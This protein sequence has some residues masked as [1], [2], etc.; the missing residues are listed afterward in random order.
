MPTRRLSVASPTVLALVALAGCGSRPQQPTGPTQGQAGQPAQRVV[1]QI[2]GTVSDTAFRTV[3]GAKVEILN[4][5]SAGTVAVSEPNGSVSFTGTFAG[6]VTFRATRDG[7]LP[8]T[9]V[10]DVAGLCPQCDAR[11]AFGMESLDP[12][13]SIEPGDYTLT[14]VAD[15]ACTRLPVELRTRTYA[16]TVTRSAD[17]PGTFDVRVPGM[18]YEHGWFGLGISGNI[19][20]TIDDSYPTFFDPLPQSAYLGIDF[21]IEAA[22]ESSTPSAI[23]VRFPGTFEYCALKTG[24]IDIRFCEFVQAS[25]LIAHDR[26]YA[27]QHQMILSRR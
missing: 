2:R 23:S 9:Q 14:F 3:A 21:A 26:C 11:I 19:V 7:Y 1:T 8:A 27:E 12:T 17:R 22:L 10:L 13:A 4:G 5:P 6:V 25:N 16:A 20:G 24:P 18:L 15:A